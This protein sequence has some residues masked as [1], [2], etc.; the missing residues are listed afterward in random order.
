MIVPRGT[1]KMK[2]ETY[3]LT[4]SIKYGIMKARRT[5]I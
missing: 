3:L 5:V 2:A 1:I 4:N